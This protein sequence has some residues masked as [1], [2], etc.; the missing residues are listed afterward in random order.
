MKNKTSILFTLL[1]VLALF[2]CKARQPAVILKN[3]TTY[4]VDSKTG[5]DANNGTSTAAP[6][7]TLAKFSGLSLKAGDSVRFA[8]GATFVGGCIIES[9]GS[10]NHP[11]VITSYG[12]G[13]Q[14]VFSNPDYSLLNGNVF[15]VKG[16][17]IT[18]DGLHFDKCANSPGKVDKDI[19]SVGAVYGITG[20][21]FLTV[22]NCLFVDCP[23]G[24]YV[25]GQHSL[26]TKNTL[27]DCNRFLSEP[28]WGPIGI[29]IGNAYN[30]V[31]YNTCTNY[32][33]VGGNY[34]ADGG[35]IELEDRYFGNKV[36]HV[37]VHHNTSIA[38]QGF[39]EIE[40][41]VTGDSLNVYYN[42]SD[43]FQ[44]FIFYWG[45]NHSR[46]DNN[47]VIRTRPSNHGSVN[48]VFTM[49]NPD[50][51]L[52]N[53]IFLVANGIQVLVTAPYNVGNY[54]KV[55]HENNIYYCLDAST[56]DPL[57]KPLG[58]GEKIIDPQFLEIA[59]SDYHLNANSPAF[60]AGQRLGYS[61]DLENKMLP[62]DSAPDI[63]AYQFK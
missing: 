32:V 16:R 9:S 26:I 14:P 27:R 47:T 20:S 30:D 49:R 11:I 13:D 31:S 18:I 15:H 63:G 46:V 24:I 17:H 40:S 2:G 5:N 57:G 6:W 28:D 22:K 34:G 25:N 53:N 45:G 59:N 37:N 43:D 21:D 41:K 36:H 60:K 50:F 61:T 52:K 4:F 38:N 7:K 12:V 48:T 39:L 19:L 51:S 35:F 29:V 55:I 58:E 3:N 33:K 62:K 56:A 54:A 1:A 44:Q 42:F 10:D 8:S 23:I